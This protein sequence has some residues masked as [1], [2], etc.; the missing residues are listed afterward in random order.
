MLPKTAPSIRRLAAIV[1][2]VLGLQACSMFDTKDK[3]EGWSANQLYVEGKE[4]LREG[5]YEDAI[6]YFETLQARYPFGR[7]AQQAAL[8]QAYANYKY[9]E[10]DAAIATLDRFIRTHPTNPYVDYAYYLRGLVNF[11][12]IS[13]LLDKFL[14]RNPTR[15]DNAAAQQSFDDF[16]ELVERFPE[17]KYA[18]DAR[19]RMMFLRNNLAIYEINVADYYMRR[20]AYVAAANRSR[21]VLEHFAYSPASEQALAIMAQAYLELD[22]LELARDATRVL[23]LNYPESP[24]LPEL[25]SR[26]TAAGAGSAP[27][28]S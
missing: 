14:P 8:D 4:S 18:N 5:N 11:Y 26:L 27:A 21:Y 25:E 9:E 13:G 23:R 2:T 10:P 24:Q 28:S 12:R 3:T 22:L 17:S 6:Q 20:G 7:Y 1:V 15:T 16:D 19:Q